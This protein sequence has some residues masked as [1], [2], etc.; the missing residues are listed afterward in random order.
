MVKWN[1]NTEYSSISIKKHDS[2]PT[3]IESKNEHVQLKSLPQEKDKNI[4]S[5]L[6]LSK[7]IDNLT[8]CLMMVE[9]EV[10]KGYLV[11]AHDL[12]IIPINATDSSNNTE[13]QFFKITE[14]V[15]EDEECSIEKLAMLYSAISYSNCTVVLMVKNYKKD[16]SSGFITDFYLGVRSNLKE[17]STATLRSQ[18]SDSLKG[19][20]P[21]TKTECIYDDQIISTKE[22]IKNT[23]CISCVT[24]IADIDYQKNI[25]NSSFFQGLEKFIDS[26][27]SVEY[28]G[29]FIADSLNY[30]D[31]LERRKD[32]EKI[33]NQLS[34]FADIQYN[35]SLESEIN[36]V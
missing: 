29:L 27:K 26:M 28:T 15:Y 13:V 3:N 12:E 34:P 20:F 23:K 11:N 32:L 36:S 35:F 4:I 21:G 24:T 1:P 14:L 30:A 2:L 16:D 10:M 19:F 9:D 31:L 22:D 18:L 33:Y 6:S 17:S 7:F 8:N 25:S 5:N